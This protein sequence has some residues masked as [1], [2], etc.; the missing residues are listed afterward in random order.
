MFSTKLSLIQILDETFDCIYFEFRLDQYNNL[1]TAY[2]YTNRKSGFKYLYCCG[3]R[4]FPS[5]VLPT[6]I[7][8][9]I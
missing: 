9:I 2:S 4:I 5:P 7:F 8:D 6:N 1:R 3:V